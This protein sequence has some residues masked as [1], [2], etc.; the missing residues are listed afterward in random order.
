M[1]MQMA[2][3]AKTKSGRI[4]LGNV[5][6][7]KSSGGAQFHIPDGIYKGIIEEVSESVSAKDNDMLIWKIKGTSGKAKNKT[8]LF[9]TALTEKAL[10][11]VNECLTALNVEIPKGPMDIDPNDLEGLEVTFE[12]MTDVYDDKPRTKIAKF[13]NGEEDEEAEEETEE[14]EEEEEEETPRKKKPIKTK[15]SKNSKPSEE[16][17]RDMSEEELDGVVGKFDLDVDLSQ[18][19]TLRRKASA[20]VAALQE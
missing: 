10:W 8:I 5:Y 6:D 18:F 20:V 1:E 16:E 17:I 14:E 19:R 15:A 7:A 12:T 11:K 13:I 2:K 9:Y 3:R 4:H